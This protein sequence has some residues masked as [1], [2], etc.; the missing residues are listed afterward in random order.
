MSSNI[1]TKQRYFKGRKT[2]MKIAKAQPRNYF[3]VNSPQ[4][5]TLMNQTMWKLEGY[6]RV[7]LEESQIPL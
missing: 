7:L 2:I 3:V 5:K 4:A 1:A 6:H